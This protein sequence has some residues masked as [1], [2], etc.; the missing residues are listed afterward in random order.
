MSAVALAFIV[1][2]GFRIVQSMN[3]M[4]PI[5]SQKTLVVLPF[6][7]DGQSTEDRIYCD[8]ITEILT[9]RLS[10]LRGAAVAPPQEVRR[11][12][13]DGVQEAREEFGATIVLSATWRRGPSSEHLTMNLIDARTGR[14]LRSRSIRFS[15]TDLLALQDRAAEAAIR[16]LEVDQ[17]QGSAAAKAGR[18]ASAAVYD[19]YLRARGYLQD[20]HKPENLESSILLFGEAIKKDPSFAPAYAGLGEAYRLQYQ[21]DNDAQKID[22]ALSACRQAVSLDTDRAEGHTCLGL[23][24]QAMGKYEQSIAELQVAFRLD[25]ASD[26]VNRSLARAYERVGRAADA[27]KTYRTAIDL[28]PQN[29]RGYHSLGVFYQN[30]AQYREAA[31]MYREV[32]RL[33]PDSFRA[34]YN[35]ATAETQ[36]GRHQEAIELCRRSLRIRPNAPAYSN[37]AAVQLGLR[38][39]REAADNFQAALKLDD[40]NYILWGNLGEALYRIPGKQAQAI[41]AFREAITKASVRLKVNPRNTAI[42]V[43]LARYNAMTGDR[44][45]ALEMLRTA[46]ALE[47]GSPDVLFR[48]ALVHAQLR[49]ATAAC[50]YLQKSLK[51]GLPVS[52]IETTA[53]FDWLRKERACRSLFPSGATTPQHP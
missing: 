4:E 33:A 45:N 8:G 46:V 31:D 18:A 11:L 2:L 35:L 1:Y 21:L 24:H 15:I 50:Q 22:Q 17:D 43:D 25:P 20:Y 3:P 16:M 6:E 40:R 32:V 34:L 38:Q 39:Y 5:P 19:C 23:V 37:L 7:P 52:E 30:Q 10:G 12:K 42:I 44:E 51:A 14:V 53:D 36:L 41:S 48:G 47:P 9:A 29:W 28:S 13:V 49:H 26:L 27:E